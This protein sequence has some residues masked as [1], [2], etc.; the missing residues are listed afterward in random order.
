MKKSLIFTLAYILI[1]FLAGLS[2]PA[3]TKKPVRSPSKKYAKKPVA[4]SA[5]KPAAM[6]STA[7]GLLY[8]ISG[9]GL[10]Q[11]SY[12]F[13]TIHILCQKDM[14]SMDKLTGYIDHSQ[15]VV[16]EI[17]MDDQAE[18]ASITGGILIPGGKT[19]TEYLKPEEV[20][21]VDELIKGALG[22]GIDQVKTIKP[23]MLESMII[24]NPK[25]LGCP[26]PSSYELSFIQIAK[27]KNKPI[28]GLETVKFQSELLDKT[29]LEKQAKGLAKIAQDPQK[30]YDNF[31]HLMDVY[32]LQDSAAL[33]DELERQTAESK[34]FAAD[35]I[36]NRNKSWIS[37]LEKEMQAHS[38]FIAVGGGHLGGDAGV[39]K[40]LKAQGYTIKPIKL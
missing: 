35:L 6:V 14:F 31:H 20:A 26:T 7:G 36:D 39:L 15:Q 16:M 32:K 10:K 12:I 17:D 8:Q 2:A 4:K 38:S 5:A 23:V 27:E 21:K 22:V 34:D 3:Q 33:H 13:G 29:P 19:F 18:M 28:V 11:P 24:A 37:K 1:L 9:R 25:V 40:L 30:A